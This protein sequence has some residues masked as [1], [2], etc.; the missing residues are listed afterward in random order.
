MSESARRVL[1]DLAPGLPWAAGAAIA[2]ALAG[3]TAWECAAFASAALAAMSAKASGSVRVLCIMLLSAGV[4]AGHD[5]PLLMAASAL[6]G[7]V[8]AHGFSARALFA[9]SIPMAFAASGSAPAAALS[10]VAAAS[11]LPESRRAR[12]LLSALG[13]ILAVSVAGLPLPGEEYE[14]VIP[15]RIAGRTVR[16]DRFHLDRSSPAAILRTPGLEEGTVGITFEAGGTRDSM[17]IGLL[18]A[19]E[20][21]SAIPPGRSEAMLQADGGFVEIRLVRPFHPFEHPVIH[22]LEAFARDE[23]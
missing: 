20:A 21:V 15:E 14:R 22:V 1:R 9:L 7:L 13:L 17:P 10:A 18:F 3:G 12:T 19:G 6:T 16:W 23:G 2:R 5:G 8:F 11:A 4:P